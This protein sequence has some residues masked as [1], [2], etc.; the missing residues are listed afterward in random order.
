MPFSYLLF[1]FFYLENPDPKGVPTQ[2]QNRIPNKLTE[3]YPFKI[4]YNENVIGIMIL[5]DNETRDVDDFSNT[6]NVITNFKEYITAFLETLL[7]FVNTNKK[8]SL[9]K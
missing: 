9:E 8:L 3:L 5:R 2:L 4:N 1:C 6:I 7:S